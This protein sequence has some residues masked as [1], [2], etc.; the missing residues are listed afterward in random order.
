MNDDAYGDQHFML[1]DAFIF[2]PFTQTTESDTSRLAYTGVGIGETRFY[3]RPYV[4]HD[5]CH[6]L[7]ATFDRHTKGEHRATAEVCIRR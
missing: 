1:G 5:G 6:V 4:F 2:H 7:A 3:D